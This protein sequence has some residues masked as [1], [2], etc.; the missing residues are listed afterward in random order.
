MSKSQIR[1]MNRTKL[2]KAAQAI[3]HNMI[4]GN[5]VSDAEIGFSHLIAE[6]YGEDTV[7]QQLN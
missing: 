2:V 4:M 1:A 5:P 7:W 3:T 6:I